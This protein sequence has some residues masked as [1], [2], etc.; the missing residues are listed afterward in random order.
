MAFTT[1]SIADVEE[2]SSKGRDGGSFLVRVDQPNN[3]PGSPPTAIVFSAILN[4]DIDGAPNCYARFNP[5]SPDGQNGGLDFLRNAI[6]TSNVGMFT[7]LAKG[8]KHHNWRWVG[9]LR[10]TVAG[11]PNQGIK[12]ALLDIKD[13]LAALNDDGN[14]ASPPMFPVLRDDNDRFYVSTSGLVKNASAALTNPLRYWDAST[15]DYAAKTPPVIRLGVEYGDFGIAIRKDTGTA[16]AF[17]YADAGN[18][19]K[20]GEM[21][22]SLFT[23]LFPGNDQEEH[24][25]AF[26]VFP[27]S[28]LRPIQNSPDAGMR[29]LL[30]NLSKAGN[31]NTVIGLMASGFPASGGPAVSE[32]MY[33][34]DG[35]DPK[36]P[37]ATKVKQL[38]HRTPDFDA[39][40]GPNARDTAR[41][42]RIITALQRFGYDPAV[43]AQA[44]AEAAQAES[45]SRGIQIQPM[46]LTGL[47]IPDPPGR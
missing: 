41:V 19:N 14:A 16:R 10:S 25:V 43:A 8:Q 24:P 26:I 20:V 3:P 2:V 35:P 36:G 13:E 29:T 23:A 40:A 21:S 1:L 4:Q 15:I 5:A 6:S 9:L 38:M 28:R 7:A 45:R 31:M 22:R 42:Q 33:S 34:Y 17:M 46:D 12:A 47:Q 11:A 27:G 32:I 30:T 44:A 37:K 18:G 39:Y